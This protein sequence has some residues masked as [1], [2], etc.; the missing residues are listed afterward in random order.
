MSLVNVYHFLY[1]HFSLFGFEDRI[2]DFIGF[3]PDHYLSFYFKCR[4][5][6]ESFYIDLVFIYCLP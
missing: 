1:V 6:A 2:Q 4:S 5:M 3:V